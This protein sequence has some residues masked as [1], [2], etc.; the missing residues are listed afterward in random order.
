VRDAE[1]AQL[2]LLAQAAHHRQVGL[3]VQQVVNLHQVDAV[4]AQ[5][6]RR[7]RHLRAARLLP[8]G[9]DFGGEKRRMFRGC[10][11]FACDG[12]GTAVHRRTV[13]EPAARGEEVA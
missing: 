9:P 13:D 1:I 8:A 5:P 10:H 7:F 12:L 4:H 11:Q 3:A 6:A 2:A